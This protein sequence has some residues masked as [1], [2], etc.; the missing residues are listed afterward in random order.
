MHSSSKPLH[1]S[2][3]PPP[4][5]VSFQDDLYRGRLPI[6]PLGAGKGCKSQSEAAVAPLGWVNTQIRVGASRVTLP[7]LLLKRIRLPSLPSVLPDI[8]GLE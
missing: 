2:S 4:F 7:L 1:A 5:R 3:V 8:G 6:S